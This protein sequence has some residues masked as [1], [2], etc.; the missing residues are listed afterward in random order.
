MYSSN[1]TPEA[2][3]LCLEP[4]TFTQFHSTVVTAADMINPKATIHK[5]VPDYSGCYQLPSFFH[6]IHCIQHIHFNLHSIL[7]QYHIYHGCRLLNQQLSAMALKYMDGI[8]G[9]GAV[10]VSSVLSMK[11]ICYDF[12]HKLS[13][14]LFAVVFRY[15]G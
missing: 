15:F 12:W 13:I 8:V 7:V 1:C 10:R 4:L 11:A 9:Q 5:T 2:C 3:K 6:E 14:L